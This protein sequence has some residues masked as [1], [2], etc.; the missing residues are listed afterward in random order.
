MVR[1]AVISLIIAAISATSVAQAASD[2]AKLR[3]GQR[4]YLSAQL[5]SDND[6]NTRPICR[7]YG[8]QIAFYRLQIDDCPH[9]RFGSLVR[10]IE[11]RPGFDDETTTAFSKD[12]PFV[13]I[14]SIDGRWTGWVESISLE[15]I[16]PTGTHLTLEKVGD[17]APYIYAHKHDPVN[18]TFEPG[19]PV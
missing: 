7:T 8:D 19:F 11:I 3:I 18:K 6:P 10:V 17:G 4:A 13:R 12:V 1:P 15:P 16:I 2:W 9:R 5:E 14:Q